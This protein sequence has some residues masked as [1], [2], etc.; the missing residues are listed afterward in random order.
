MKLFAL[1]TW[2]VITTKTS[3]KCMP[4]TLGFDRLYS[5]RLKLF[6]LIKLDAGI[7]AFTKLTAIIDKCSIMAVL[8][9]RMFRE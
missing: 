7:C 9:S 3:Y 2:P 4:A 5:Y 8:K 1:L 6:S